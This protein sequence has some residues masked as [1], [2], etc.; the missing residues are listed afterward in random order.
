MNN[1]SQITVDELAIMINKGFMA[2]DRSLKDNL[3]SLETRLGDRIDGLE[4]HMNYRL[5]GLQNQLDNIYLNYITRREHGLL[6]DRVTKIERK[7][8]IPR[9]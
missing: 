5:D 4:Q 8:G 7:V 2:A 9:Q 1:G 3:A 6:K